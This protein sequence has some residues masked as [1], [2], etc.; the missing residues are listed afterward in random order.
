[1]IHAINNGDHLYLEKEHLS[2]LIDN[3]DKEPL[4][5]LFLNNK[6]SIQKIFNDESYLSKLIDKIDSE[7]L[8]NLLNKKHNSTCLIEIIKNKNLLNKL[9]KKLNKKELS[10]LCMRHP[11]ILMRI[12]NDKNMLRTLIDGVDAKSWDKMLLFNS[13]NL[14]FGFFRKQS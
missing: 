5:K 9:I 7:P 11:S 8:F 10:S 3:L 1:M 2:I 14:S 4:Y 13:H 12:Y 6:H